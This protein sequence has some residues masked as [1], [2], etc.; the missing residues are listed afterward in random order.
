[1]KNQFGHK[2]PSLLEHRLKVQE[3]SCGKIEYLFGDDVEQDALIYLSYQLILNGQL[4]WKDVKK[5][6]REGGAL[7]SA[8]DRMRSSFSKLKPNTNVVRGIFIRL[9]KHQVPKWMY[10][11]MPHLIPV[12]TWSQAGIKLWSDG[13]ISIDVLRQICTDEGTTPIQFA[14][15]VQDLQM[16]GLIA[17]DDAVSLLTLSGV[18]QRYLFKEDAAKPLLFTDVIAAFQ[19]AS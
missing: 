15:L 10:N 16:R 9:T 7:S 1:M 13:I 5:L 6:M 17:R 4:Q 3:L 19:E 12:H 14:N 18:E 2:L 8:V 11:L